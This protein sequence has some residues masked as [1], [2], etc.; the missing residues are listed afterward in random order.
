MGELGGR[1]QTTAGQDRPGR[2]TRLARLATRQHGVAAHHQLIRLSFTRGVIEHRLAT[3]WLQPLYRGVYA[4]GHSALTVHGR[5]M[6]AVLACGPGAVLSHR[7]AADLWGLRPS[8]RRDIDVTARRG[9]AGQ[10]GITLHRPRTFHPDDRTVRERI[11]VTTVARTLLDLAEVL[12]P[13]QLE[14]AVEEAE[15]RRLFDLRAVERLLARSH[16]RR[17]ARRLRQVLAPRALPA[18]EARSELERRFVDLCRDAGLPLPALNVSVEGFIVDALWPNARLI[19]ELD[20][21]AFHR[22]RKAFEADRAR[23]AALQLAD[24]RLL[25]I[26]Y[27]RLDAEPATI[28]AMLRRALR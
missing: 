1:T 25:R 23:D 4:V 22:T 15:R 8:G 18:L 17:G 14:R 19:V 26:T 21:F 24:Y 13:R 11:P 9:R 12:N 10:P 20:G 6:A 16:G 28:V 7:D 2:D 27:R 3:G 5:W